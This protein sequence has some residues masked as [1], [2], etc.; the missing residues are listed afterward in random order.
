[1]SS[2]H[3]R[4]APS[5][6]RS[7]AQKAHGQ[8]LRALPCPE[9]LQQGKSMKSVKGAWYVTIRQSPA[10]W[11]GPHF[12]PGSLEGLRALPGQNPK[13]TVP[14]LPPTPLQTLGPMFP[15]VMHGVGGDQSQGPLGA[16]FCVSIS[17]RF[18]L[19]ARERGQR[20]GYLPCM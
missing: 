3:Y 18:V 10:T 16:N 12:I 2:T 1:M 19:E 14:I 11:S 4:G 13:R 8:H 7:H 20:K 17:G 6:E 15:K 5:K 9:C